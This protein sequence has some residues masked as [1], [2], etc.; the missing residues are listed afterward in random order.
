MIN[1]K[2]HINSIRKDFPVLH[3]EVNGY[4]LVYF[5]NAASAQ[6]PIAVIDTVSHYYSFEHSNIHRGVHHLS[7]EATAKYEASRK[8]IQLHLNAV[9]DHEIIFTKGTTD[10]INLVANGFRSLLKKGDEIIVSELEHHSNIVPWQMACE[11]T[12]AILKVIPINDRGEILVEEFKNLVSEKTKLIAVNHVSNTL[13]TINPVKEIIDYAH[14]YE[15]PVLLD[16]AQAVPHMKVNIQELD[17]DFYAFSGHKLYGPTGIGVLYG[18]EAWLNKLPPYQ[19][20][21]DMIKSVSFENT[22]YNEL[23]FKFEAGTPNIA[24]ALGL[25]AAIDYANEIGFETIFSYENELHNYAMTKMAELSD[26]DYYGTSENKAAV[27]SFLL[28]GIHPYDTGTILDKLGI[29]VRT[30]HHCTEPI[31]TRY[32]IPGTVRASFSFYNTFEE[33]DRF[34]DGLKRVQKMFG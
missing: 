28:K 19:G 18:K 7:A 1:I 10:G 33:I 12:G 34:I 5:D 3:Q 13:G 2:E 9:H 31:M 26:V 16:G 20:G 29:A 24:G 17:C 23:P 21:G 22:T 11:Q 14:Q 30:G 15:I 32:S 8:T 27:I 6:K 25:K 4:P